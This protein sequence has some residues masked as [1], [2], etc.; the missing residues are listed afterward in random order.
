MW[1]FF[2]AAEQR[3]KLARPMQINFST[4]TD[5]QSIMIFQNLQ[6]TP[7]PLCFA[8]KINQMSKKENELLRR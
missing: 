2:F 1:P 5:G 8:R 4:R 3:A 7:P 6:R